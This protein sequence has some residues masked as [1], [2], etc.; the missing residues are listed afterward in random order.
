MSELLK[1]EVEGRTETGKGPNRRLRET[2]MVPGVYYDAKGH[3]IPVK[4][5]FVALSKVVSAVG[6][7]KVFELEIDRDGKSET[8]PCLIK[9]IHH[10][11]LKPIYNHVD[12][13]GV[14]LHKKVVVSIPVRVEGKAV[15][16]TR[17]GRLGIFRETVEV[18][19]LPKDI[20][21]SL[22]LDVTDLD[23][24]HSILIADVEFGEGVSA[25]YEDNYAVVGVVAPRAVEEKDEDEEEVAEVAPEE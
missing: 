23:L 4:V 7:A 25:V 2:G 17:G 1:L 21:D 12:F 15:G 3:N 13:F 11:P 9:D 14:D 22:T 10:H 6:Y 19:C 16:V 24:G 18:E 20:P 8:M 5:D